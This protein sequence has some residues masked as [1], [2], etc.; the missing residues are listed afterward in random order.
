MFGLLL[1]CLCASGMAAELDQVVAVVNNGVILRSEL[2]AQVREIQARAAGQPNGRLPAEA[3]LRKQ[4]LEQMIQ[5]EIQLQLADRTGIRVSDDAVNQAVAGIARRN[6]MQLDAFIAAVQ[7]EGQSYAALREDIRKDLAID[8]L[9]Q[10][11]V[12]RRIVVTDREIDN[13]IE[14]LN[15]RESKAVGEASKTLVRETRARHILMRP[16]VVMNDAKIRATLAN[17]RSQLVAGGDF[18]ALAKQYSDDATAD[19]GGELGWVARGAVVP[20]FQQVMDS[21]EPGQISEPFRSRFGWHIVQVTERRERDA[22]DEALRERA[23]Q[24]VFQ[25]KLE[26]ATQAWQRRL[27]EEAYVE[28]RLDPGT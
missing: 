24:Q 10:R 25:R 3:T 22:T 9:R 13:Q 7:A 1:L 19:Q 8:Q 4:V 27:R 14:T 26:E 28:I 15:A 6:N 16:S 2:D 18:A 20:E 21:L 17:V 11:E 12:G 23:R 5:N